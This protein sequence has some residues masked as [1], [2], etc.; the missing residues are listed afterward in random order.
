MIFP[1]SFETTI[2]GLL[3]GETKTARLIKIGTRIL[4]TLDQTIFFDIFIDF[5]SFSEA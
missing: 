5:S 4:A 3:L 1:K 2:P